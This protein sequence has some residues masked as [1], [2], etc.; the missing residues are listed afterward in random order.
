VTAQ[1]WLPANIAGLPDASEVY[2]EGV[3]SDL[4]VCESAQGG[5]WCRALLNTGDGTIRIKV[6]PAVFANHR[7]ALHDGERIAV[8]GTLDRR[9][10]VPFVLVKEV[11]W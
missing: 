4:V 1:S 11:K 6:Y 2:V 10:N 7:D 3:L 8:V 9:E 5:Q